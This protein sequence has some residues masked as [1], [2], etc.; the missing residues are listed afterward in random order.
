MNVT[1]DLDRKYSMPE[2]N[3]SAI[4]TG[5]ELVAAF[6]SLYPRT[7]DNVTTIGLVGVY[8]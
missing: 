6:K 5:I 4:L 7:D 2:N 1:S 3:S 8:I